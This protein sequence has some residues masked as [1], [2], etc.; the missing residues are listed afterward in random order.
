MHVN[1]LNVIDSHQHFWQ[2]SRGDYAWLTPELSK[3]Y[4]DFL[5]SDFLQEVKDINVSQTILVQASNTDAE[6]DFML[7]LA[8]DNDFIG[9][10]VGW[11][12]FEGEIETVCQRLQTLAAN[13][14]FKG[15]RPMLQDIDDPNWILTPRFDAI[16]KQLISL[17]LSFDALINSQHIPAL[18]TIAKR[19]PNLNIVIDHCA[20]P[21][22]AD[23]Q[24][25]YWQQGIA[26]FIKLANVS[27][28]VSGLTTEASSQQR[29]P[30]DYQ[31]YLLYML[32]NFG[33]QRLMW[34]SDWPVVNL[35]SSYHK[36][37]EICEN[38]TVDW[39]A[40]DFNNLF[41]YSAAKFYKLDNLFSKD[42]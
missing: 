33:S 6:T 7:Q 29:S 23:R 37:L 34:G 21:N 14:K 42:K 4:R 25:D 38:I 32:Q 35:N 22:I 3:L 26:K 12:D 24:F 16:F 18:E 8:A 28:K 20:K 39:S 30:Q 9:G 31:D 40:Q 2:L 15:V 19:Y 36:W 10:V 13:P 27:V 17:N 5:P 11:I 1:S 41:H